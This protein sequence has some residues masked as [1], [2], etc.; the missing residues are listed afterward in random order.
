MAYP[1]RG[2]LQEREDAAKFVRPRTMLQHD[3]ARTRED[4]EP[5]V[6]IHRTCW[7]DP[8]QEHNPHK[9]HENDKKHIESYKKHN[10]IMRNM[11]NIRNAST[12]NDTLAFS[13]IANT[14]QNTC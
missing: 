1:L 9:K 13:S 3:R 4:C 10:I 14:V 2:N 7:V 11:R 5:N 8:S 6:N 12:M